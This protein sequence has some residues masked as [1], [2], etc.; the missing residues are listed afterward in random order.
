MV[1][2]SSLLIVEV[3]FSHGETM[4]SAHFPVILKSTEAPE[5]NGV[6]PEKSISTGRELDQPSAIS[7]GSEVSNPGTNREAMSIY[8]SGRT[9]DVSRRVFVL[10]ISFS[11]A[12]IV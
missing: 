8:E 9:I 5:S 6:T 12:F 3:L 7:G 2:V 4:S 10:L 11:I 1:D